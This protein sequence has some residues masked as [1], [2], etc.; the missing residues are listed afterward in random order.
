M[1]LALARLLIGTAATGIPGAGRHMR[2]DEMRKHI[3]EHFQTALAA[4]KERVG[5]DGVPTAQSLEAMQNSL[6]L[7]RA[8]IL[9]AQGSQHPDG[10]A[11]IL[12][13][14]LSLRGVSEAVPADRQDM[15]LREYHIGFQAYF[16]EAFDTCGH[17]MGTTS[18]RQSRRASSLFMLRP[19]R[20]PHLSRALL[21]RRLLQLSPPTYQRDAAAIFGR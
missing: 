19:K 12:R 14:L 20:T 4:F 16:R 13:T 2:Y 7:D 9:A 11:G 3:R 1:A 8:D 15:M 18:Q 6:D 21:H 10:A 5:S 17:S